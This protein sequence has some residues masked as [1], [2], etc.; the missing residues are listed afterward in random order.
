MTASGYGRSA[1]MKVRTGLA[2]G[3]ANTTTT[4]LVYESPDDSA[5]GFAAGLRECQRGEPAS[6]GEQAYN[7]PCFVLKTSSIH[8]PFAW[9]RPLSCLFHAASVMRLTVMPYLSR[10]GS[11]NATARSR[12]KSA[13]ESGD[14]QVQ[15]VKP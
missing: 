7:R 6:N 5:D 11:R 12:S 14:Q 3:Q 15:R 13:C 4:N 10:S 8:S 9:F 1:R 2:S